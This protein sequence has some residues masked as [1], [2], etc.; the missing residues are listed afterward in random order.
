MLRYETVLKT[1]NQFKKHVSWFKSTTDNKLSDIALYEY[2]GQYKINSTD[3]VRTNPKTIQQMK[4]EVQTKQPKDVY[5]QMNRDNSLLAPKDTKQIRNANYR[6]KKTTQPVY[7][8]NIADEILQV[9]S[10]MNTHPCVQ[11]V[12]HT[13]GQVPSII[14]YTDDQMTDLKHYLHKADNPIV[15]V[16]RTFNLGSFFVTSLVYKNHMVFRKETKDQPIFAG[17]MLLHK[18]ATYPTYL[19][20]CSH[21]SALIKID[22][23]E[24]RIPEDIEFGSDDK[25]AMTN[26]ISDA[27]PQAR[28]RLCT[29]H[30]KD[31]VKHYLQNRIGVDS[32]ERKEIMDSL[33]GT[34]DNKLWT[35]CL[36][37]L[38]IN[39]GLSVWY[40]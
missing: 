3:K 39:Y 38:T 29:K 19:S 20:F 36:V 23:L 11:Q 8:N 31:N 13:K 26:A 35:L 17:P 40:S 32:K 2:S 28:R 5:L 37:L 7:N 12:I 14:C 27:F 34:L 1:N 6:E 22:N 25:K 9:L 33:F 30:L 10:M 4:T 24:L 16:D 21:L 18:D 15:G